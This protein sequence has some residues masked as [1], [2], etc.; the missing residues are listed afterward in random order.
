MLPLASRRVVCLTSRFGCDQG[1][2]PLPQVQ[3]AK[4]HQTIGF[5]AWNQPLATNRMA[6][7]RPGK[8]GV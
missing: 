6:E 5:T 4:R 2:W 8:A 3:V 1:L 7:R